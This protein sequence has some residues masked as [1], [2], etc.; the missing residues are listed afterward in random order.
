MRRI[1]YMLLAA[2]VLV[3]G[4][5]GCQQKIEEPMKVVDLRYRAE[6]SYDLAARGAKAFTILV[7]STD[8]W[9]VTSEHPD[10]CIISEEE[11][12]A[13]DPELV[14]TGKA[15]ATT[16]RVQ[17]YDNLGLDGRDDKITIKSDYWIG[18]VIS[19]HQA[20]IAY[21]TVPEAELEQDVAK[22]GGAY[23]IHISSNQNWTARVTDGDWIS[24][25]EGAS[26][27]GDGTVTV[28]AEDNAK[29]L[30]Y[31]EVTVYDRHNEVAATIHYTQDG[32]QLVPSVTEIRAG[33]DQPTTELEVKSNTKWT[34]V[35]ES[36]ADDWFEVLTPSGEGDGTIRI[37]LNQNE[38]SRIRSGIIVLK[39]VVESE[40]DFVAE[41]TIVLKQAYKVT[42]VVHIFNNDELGNW[43]VESSTQPSY[44]SGSGMYF[45]NVCTLQNG[46]M[47]FGDYTFYWKDINAVNSG[48]RIRVV[49]AYND[50]EEIKFGLR[51]TSG[52]K[53]AMY[54]DFNAASSGK[55]GKPSGYSVP[56]D[57]DFSV[58]HTFGCRFL[59]IIDS[60]YC[61]VCIYL[62]GTLI[63]EFDTSAEIMD[64]V[65]WGTKINMYLSVDSGGTG[66]SAVLEKYEYSEPLNW[67]D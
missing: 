8:P 19:I 58:A 62:D 28:F 53:N 35:K 44:I 48:V 27:T 34:A 36:D 60:E 31:A 49:F 37:A 16:I 43:N 18:K 9:T 40:G 14:H 20:G 33:Y 3:T 32:V 22:T 26:G 59:P 17:Y 64:E 39:N 66:D 12:D 29:E 24:I 55:S 57:I 46:S 6:D 30:R 5:A 54:L 51:I 25:T 2:T 65:K 13:S 1:I 7:A 61:H 52:G 56:E 10:W 21:L 45:A 38:G 47:P 15:E 42:P 50:I 67:D 63:F 11:G 41:K 23:A 4:L